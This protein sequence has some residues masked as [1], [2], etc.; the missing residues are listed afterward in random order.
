MKK[1]KKNLEYTVRFILILATLLSNFAF[2]PSIKA[3][4]YNKG[5]VVEPIKSAGDLNKEGN[6][7]LQKTVSK[8]SE[9]GIYDVTLSVSGKDKKITTTTEVVPYI[10]FVLDI[11][12]TMEADMCLDEYCR[13]EST[14]YEIARDSAIDFSKKLIQKYPKAQIALVTF[15]YDAYLDRDFNNSAFTSNSFKRV[16]RSVWDN[17][18]S[19]LESATNIAAGI[20]KANQILSGKENKYTIVL[21]DGYPESYD[22]PSGVNSYDTDTINASVEAKNNNVD[23][24][25]I[26]F[27]FDSEWKY[28]DEIALLKRVASSESKFHNAA[29]KDELDTSF[30]S[31]TNSINVESTVNA[32][33]DANITD[34]IADGFTYVEGSANPS[35]AI[36]NNK[37]ITFKVGNITESGTT[38]SFKIKIDDTLSTGLHDTN[39]SAKVTYKNYLNEDKVLE[40]TDSSKVYWENY[41]YTVKYYKDSVS[42]SNYLGEVSG[43][44]KLNDTIIVDENKF[45]PE[46]GYAQI[47]DNKDFTLDEDNKIV[48]IVYKKKNT[49]SYIVQYFKELASGE[50]KI[51]DDN[52]NTVTDKKYQDVVTVEDIA[53]NKYLP[54]FGYKEGTVKTNMPYTIDDGENI[55]KVCY[56]RRNDLSYTVKY[57]DENNEELLPSEVREN[58]TYNETY[59]E[60][61]KEAPEGYEL[62]DDATKTITLDK[63]VNELVF[64]YNVRTDYKYTVKYVDENNEELIPS[65]VRENKTYNETYEESAKEAPEGYVLDDD[66]TK[67]ITL[68]KDNKELV[69]KYTIRTD[70]KYTVKY[71]DENNKEL[72]PSVVRENKTYNETYTEVA[73][74][75]EGYNLVSDNTQ[76]I[77]IDKDNKELVFKYT[78]RTDYKY[79]VKYVDENNKELIPSVVREN[80]TYNE[81]YTEVAEAIEGYVLDDDSTKTITLDKDN[82]ELVFKYA[83]RTDYKYTVKYVDE[84]NK[85]LIPSVLRENKT[86]NETY[87]EVAEVIEGYNL[88]SDNTQSITMDEDNKELVFTYKVI[89]VIYTINEYYDDELTN[90]YEKE[91]KYGE[92]LTFEEKDGYTLEVEYLD[93]N[94]INLYY[95]SIKTETYEVPPKTNVNNTYYLYLLLSLIIVGLV[96]VKKLD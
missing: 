92:E 29:Q 80:K 86:Y 91:V 30:L 39:D 12:T 54:I 18:F 51:S 48:N 3:D 11:S 58:K 79:T 37:N 66:S 19:G 26:G 28:S 89:K 4:T 60:S 62:N 20:R 9:E 64:K 59:E 73:E 16:R 71:V 14:R 10:V 2:I 6:V 36:I 93:N 84:N 17:E 25:T 69:F 55:I 34:V 63:E 67:T 21:T 31:I 15:G 78:I 70:Y 68:D 87:T 41:S 49:L 46:K 42:E 13:D 52:D 88:V 90:T 77:T 50:E 75:I 57:V 53:I 22:L 33:K 81:T 1:I 56:E 72:I 7:F 95:K 94:V 96:K 61:A 27:G 5:D 35:N 40:I 82:K 76:S 44:G 45:I 85:E 8:T 65:V 32:G 24:Y 74:V 38:V 83:I 23:L 47:T 43:N